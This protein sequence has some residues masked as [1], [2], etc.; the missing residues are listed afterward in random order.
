MKNPIKYLWMGVGF[1][2]MGLGAVG[3]VLP[4]LPTVP[5][6]LLAM[7]CFAKSSEKLHRWFMNTKLYK[8][9]LAT[10]VKKEGMTVKTK[11]GI[12]I[13]V[14]ILMAIGFA[15]MG[16]VP[17]G[18]IILAVVWAAHLIYFIFIVRTISEKH[19]VE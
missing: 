10:Y 2:A 6:L 4:I 7:F 1:L 5:F 9:H 17:I 12:I 13:P 15:L 18:R 14:T 8:N 16:R 3:V 19:E 11:L